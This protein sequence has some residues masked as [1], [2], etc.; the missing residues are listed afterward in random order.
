MLVKDI[1]DA[2]NPTS[3]EIEY[4]GYKKGSWCRCKSEDIADA[5]FFD[6]HTNKLDPHDYAAGARG[7]AC[8]KLVA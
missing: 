7:V 5:E 2:F 4:F 1:I 8:I 3:Y 6:V